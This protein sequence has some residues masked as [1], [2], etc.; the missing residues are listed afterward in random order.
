M[1]E[2]SEELH[3]CC[4]ARCSS[5]SDLLDFSKQASAAS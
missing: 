1:E 2:V 5:V 3:A 4:V